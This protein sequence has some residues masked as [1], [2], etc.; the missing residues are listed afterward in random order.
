MSLEPHPPS[1]TVPPTGPHPRKFSREIHLLLQQL[2]ERP[3]SL[4]EILQETSDHGVLLLIG[5]LVLP[6]LFPMPPGVT[7]VLGSGCLLLCL[8][9]SFVQG[10]PRLPGRIARFQFPQRLVRQLLGKLHRLTRLLEKRT[11]PRWLHIA[12]H[13]WIHRINGLCMVWLTLLL[14]SPVP[15]TNPVP[16]VGILLFVVA[17]LE[18]DGLLLCI[19][20]G[21]TGVITGAVGLVAYGVWRSPGWIQQ[22]LS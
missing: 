15:F 22:I 14:M 20:Y 5:L 17:M 7:T 8:Q 21:M 6:F 11:K 2:A 9:I 13:P 19:A 3:L 4:G 12:E 18:S 1:S 16:T 10:P